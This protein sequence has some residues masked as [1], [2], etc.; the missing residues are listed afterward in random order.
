MFRNCM[1][2]A[3]QIWFLVA[4]HYGVLC[5]ATLIQSIFI[6]LISMASWTKNGL[7]SFCLVYV[8]EKYLKSIDK[9]L[10]VSPLS[11]ILLRI[12]SP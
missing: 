2:I 12:L 1:R 6:I 9:S 5:S 11:F 8:D 10:Y 7:I 3:L 4:R